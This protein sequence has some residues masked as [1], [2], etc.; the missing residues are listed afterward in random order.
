MREEAVAELL[1]R[2]DASWQ[3]VDELL[4]DDELVRL[5]YEEIY[6]KRKLFRTGDSRRHL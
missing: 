6:Y 4:R 5:E 1:K 2:A 3:I